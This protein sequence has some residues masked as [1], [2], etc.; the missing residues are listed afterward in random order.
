[1]L[2]RPHTVKPHRGRRRTGPQAVAPGQV[3]VDSRRR[4]ATLELGQVD[5]N[6]NDS[7]FKAF[8]PETRRNPHTRTTT[9]MTPRRGDESARNHSNSK[10]T[11]GLT[12]RCSGLAR[13][14]SFAGKLAGARSP[15]KQGAPAAERNVSPSTGPHAPPDWIPEPTL[16]VLLDF[17]LSAPC[18]SLQVLTWASA[19]TC[20][21]TQTAA[22]SSQV[23]CDGH[24]VDMLYDIGSSGIITS[25][26]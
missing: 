17:H 3:S 12:T 25:S 16:L 24:D 9:V 11:A 20:S 13:L 1:M 10:A 22:A 2:A 8:G 15:A 14:A 19:G 26:R 18:I 6:D 4:P 23:L 7:L 21:T 5:D